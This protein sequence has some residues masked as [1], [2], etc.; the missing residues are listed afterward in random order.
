[1]HRR[2]RR[3][4]AR[5][6]V[7]VDIDGDLVGAVSRKAK[8]GDLAANDYAL[9]TV[10]LV[11]RTLKNLAGHELTA[12]LAADGATKRDESSG[13]LRALNR[14]VSVGWD[15]VGR[16]PD[17]P[18]LRR[19]L[20]R[21][22]L[23]EELAACD[24]DGPCYRCT[25]YAIAGAGRDRR[26]AKAPELAVR[27]EA[28]DVVS[29]EAADN[30]S[31]LD[32]AAQALE[33][34]AAHKRAREEFASHGVLQNVVALALAGNAGPHASRPG[35]YKFDAAVAFEALMDAPRETFQRV[36]T[37]APDARGKHRARWLVGDVARLVVQTL[38]DGEARPARRL[39]TVA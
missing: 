2:V 31:V 16:V 14:L 33:R 26:R 1:M 39:R 38:E 28:G 19:F 29:G 37:L 6:R 22:H 5:V 12:A 8:A 35:R 17:R 32:E 13:E 15:L 27:A 10:R 21:G 7:H 4:A 11:A 24:A 30:I 20:L 23:A 18:K 25:P 36:V 9:L 34:L 3:R